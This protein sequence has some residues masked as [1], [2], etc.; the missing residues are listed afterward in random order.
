MHHL[1]A[2]MENYAESTRET[3]TQIEMDGTNIWNRILFPLNDNK[4]LMLRPIQ[5]W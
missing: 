2:A 3:L 1:H 5:P 4:E